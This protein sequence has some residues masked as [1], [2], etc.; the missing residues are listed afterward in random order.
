MEGQL[1]E[2]QLY[3]DSYEWQASN[4]DLNELLRLALMTSYNH[5]KKI[6]TL[7]KTALLQP[8]QSWVITQYNIQI[9]APFFCSGAS[10]DYYASD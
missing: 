1:Q 9:V 10:E 5:D 7:L 3:T 2:W 6:K 4:W 8:E